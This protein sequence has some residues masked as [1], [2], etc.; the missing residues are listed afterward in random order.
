MYSR[1]HRDATWKGGRIQLYGIARDHPIA[2]IDTLDN[3]GKFKFT[4]VTGLRARVIT[5]WIIWND[6]AF[7]YLVLESWCQAMSGIQTA[8]V[9]TTPNLSLGNAQSR[10]DN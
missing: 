2:S 5:G 3:P 7:K 10:F 9:V 8:A 4:A 6:L 1:T